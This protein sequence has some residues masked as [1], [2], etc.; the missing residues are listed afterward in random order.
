MSIK[1]EIIK[2]EGTE[3][4][5]APLSPA[6]KIGN[7]VFTSGQT[8][9]DARDDIKTQTRKA[10]ERVKALLEAAGTSMENV[11][12]C[13]VYLTNVDEWGLMNEVYREYFPDK[14]PARSAIQIA[15][16]VGGLRVEIEAVA[17]VP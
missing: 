6:V 5:G 9:D 14:P 3:I 10:L 16:L 8:G 12:K 17:Y 7:F 1:K 2:V 11:V 4:P 15:G 13:T